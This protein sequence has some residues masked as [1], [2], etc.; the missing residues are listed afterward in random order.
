MIWFG[1]GGEFDCVV[2]TIYLIGYKEWAYHARQQL[3]MD[4][5]LDNTLKLNVR[6]CG[7]NVLLQTTSTRLS[8]S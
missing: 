8:Q 3:N 6:S 2:Y 7:N 4:A 5:F 1:A